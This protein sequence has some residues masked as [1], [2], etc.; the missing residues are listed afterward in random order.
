VDRLRI[1]RSA[2]RPTLTFASSPPG[3]HARALATHL[4]AVRLITVRYKLLELVGR[5]DILRRDLHYTSWQFCPLEL[6]SEIEE[7]AGQ[8][9]APHLCTLDG[10]TN[11][12]ALLC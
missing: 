6:W 9:G 10:S 5:H 1:A 11:S 7:A 8:R 3:K 12:L 4:Q 2:V